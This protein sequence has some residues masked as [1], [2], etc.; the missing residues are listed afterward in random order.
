L[1]A[2]RFEVGPKP[3]QVS[4]AILIRRVDLV[5]ALEQ[6][7]GGTERST[8]AIQPAE[9]GHGT[10]ELQDDRGR[11]AV[12][13][14]GHEW[15]GRLAGRAMVF[16]CLFPPE[17]AGRGAY[18]PAAISRGGVLARVGE[19]VRVVLTE[20]VEACDGPARVSP[21][22]RGVARL[23]AGITALIEQPSEHESA[24][25]IVLLSGLHEPVD[26]LV[27]GLEGIGGPA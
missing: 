11:G 12:L 27:E 16:R 3:F 15:L 19:D 7:S 21:R 26:C 6:F 5:G 8:V 17:R 25:R 14:S 10:G 22:T 24:V 20:L 2:H 18:G 1:S 23:G 13:L 4:A 9:A